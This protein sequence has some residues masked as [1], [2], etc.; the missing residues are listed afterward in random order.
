VVRYETDSSVLL[1]VSSVEAARYR[2][3][4]STDF[5]SPPEGWQPPYPYHRDDVLFVREREIEPKF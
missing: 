3:V 2:D 4:N 1:D 5:G